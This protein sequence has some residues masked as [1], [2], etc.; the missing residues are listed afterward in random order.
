[1]TVD[2]NVEPKLSH[3]VQGD[4]LVPVQDLERLA[5]D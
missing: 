1:M 5:D 4:I 2:E 3:V